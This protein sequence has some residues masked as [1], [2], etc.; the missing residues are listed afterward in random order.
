MEPRPAIVLGK[1]EAQLSNYGNQLARKSQ[2]FSRKTATITLN[3][4]H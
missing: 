3:A 2:A 4:N 1:P